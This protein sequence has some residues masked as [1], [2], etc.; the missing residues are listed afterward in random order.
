M[1]IK[2]IITLTVLTLAFSSSIFSQVGI[3]TTT[4]HAS[5]ELDVTSTSKGFLLPRMTTVQR[6]LI[7]SPAAGLV[8]YN[9]STSKAEVNV[10]SS[11]APIWQATSSALPTGTSGQT[12]RHDGTNWVANSTIINTG[13]N[14]GIGTTSPVSNLDIQGSLGLKVTT[15]TAATAL[16][17][18]HNV[19]LCNTGPYTVSLPA[20]A[21]NTGKVYYIKNID[22][23]GDAI[24]IDGNGTE[25]I[26]ANLT[27]SLNNY[28]HVV[29]IIS[30][31]N[32]WH[33]IDEVNKTVTGFI[34]ALTCGSA[35]SNGTLTPGTAASGV[36]SAVPYTG[37]N[38]GMHS[39]Q[40]VNSSGVTGLTAMLSSGTFSNGSG[41][42]TYTIMGTPASHGTATFALNI[43]GQACNLTRTVT[44]S[45]S[46]SVGGFNYGIVAGGAGKC[47]LDRNLGATQIA[48]S[49]TDANAYG[50]YYQWGRLADGHQITIST[51]TTTT[52]STTDNPG[53]ALFI[54]TT[55][56]YVFRSPMNYS[57]WQGVNG[58]NN[59]C[60][61]GFRIPTYAELNTERASWSSNNAAGAFASPLKLPMAGARSASHESRPAPGAG[62][63]LWA[64]SN[65]VYTGTALFFNASSAGGADTFRT[66]GINVR[67]IKD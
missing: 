25:N 17:Q 12:L 15:I 42:L 62:G 50:H 43:G 23:E 13:T 63:M 21:S 10:G 61:S 46:A 7:G 55:N 29:R 49:S 16:D 59:P 28:H 37:G 1:K 38:G 51:T 67:C 58:G 65:T 36:T 9:T 19:V 66:D 5:A 48:T 18:T 2:R 20:A 34:S 6:D 30:D 47:W 44:C 31:G 14:V 41:S 60:P 35:S 24:T 39:G 57:L 40:I 53:N 33:I 3:G 8:I 52:Q 32:N 22:A 26:N 11:V 54:V 56:G 64:A 27:Y 45:G 4:P